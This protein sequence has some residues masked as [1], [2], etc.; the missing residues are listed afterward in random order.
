MSCCCEPP[1]DFSEPSEGLCPECHKPVWE[2]LWTVGN[3][4]EL[5]T[6]GNFE[7]HCTY[8][9]PRQYPIFCDGSC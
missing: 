2:W 8:C 5:V 3:E 4:T 7:V 1:Y 6:T 9:N